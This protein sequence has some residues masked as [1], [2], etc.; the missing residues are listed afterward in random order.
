MKTTILL[1]ILYKGKSIEQS[2]AF[3]IKCLRP[4]LTISNNLVPV[5]KTILKDALLTKTLNIRDSKSRKE[6]QSALLDQLTSKYTL[7][8]QDSFLTNFFFFRKLVDWEVK[9]KA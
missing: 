4:N 2:N 1:S 6:C 7:D 8:I 3:T 9:Y 5:E